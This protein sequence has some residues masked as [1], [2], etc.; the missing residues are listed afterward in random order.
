METDNSLFNLTSF[1]FGNI[2]ASGL[3]EDDILDDDC[4]KYLNSL[5]KLGLQPL[6]TE[7]IGEEAIKGEKNDADSVSFD[8]KSPSAKDYFDEMELAS[9][10]TIVEAANKFV[11]LPN[12]FPGEN[13]HTFSIPVTSRSLNAS[14][15]S[16]ERGVKNRKRKL[17]TPLAAMLP[18]KYADV[19]V[20][21]FFPD[22]RCGKV[23]SMIIL[24][25]EIDYKT[26]KTYLSCFVNRF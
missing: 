24:A 9:E 1:L 13:S 21:E 19:D 10:S 11:N 14:T 15:G 18:E 8:I 25:F 6:L 16:M 7:V 23:R 22:F 5:G 3:L 4:K 2:D 26:R 17:E 20:R 12:D